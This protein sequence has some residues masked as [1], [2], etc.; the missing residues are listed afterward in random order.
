MTFPFKV[1]LSLFVYSGYANQMFSDR[2][3]SINRNAI[4]S[5]PLY[6][7]RFNSASPEIITTFIKYAYKLTVNLCAMMISIFQYT[8][9]IQYSFLQLNLSMDVN[10]KETRCI[11]NF[12]YVKIMSSIFSFKRSDILFSAIS[13]NKT[14]TRNKEKGTY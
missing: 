3:H 12:G 1:E 11:S 9:S 6:F 5:Y 10:M 7:V 2:Q 13:S 14:T 8:F 4:L